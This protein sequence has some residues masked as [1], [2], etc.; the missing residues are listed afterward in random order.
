MRPDAPSQLAGWTGWL[1]A[2]LQQ[3]AGR[4]AR[5]QPLSDS[6][7]TRR[8]GFSAAIGMLQRPL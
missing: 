4:P 6:A 8:D 2:G 5:K 7:F 1:A 3:P